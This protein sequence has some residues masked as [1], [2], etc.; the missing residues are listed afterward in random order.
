MVTRYTNY[1]PS[2]IEIL[3]GAG[4]VA[5]GVLAVSLGVRYLNVIDHQPVEEEAETAPVLAPAD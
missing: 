1:F 3:A 5:Y 2:L 4:V